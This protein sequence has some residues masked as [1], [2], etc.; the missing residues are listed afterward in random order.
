[1][2]ADKTHDQAKAKGLLTKLT[3]YKFVIHLMYMRELLAPLSR[4]SLN[5]QKDNVGIQDVLSSLDYL[6]EKLQSLETGEL[7]GDCNDD[8]KQLLQQGRD[9]RDAPDRDDDS[10]VKFQNIKLTYVSPSVS[11]FDNNRHRYASKII[12]SCGHRF[13][14]DDIFSC[15]KILD[16]RLWPTSSD[17]DS[18]SLKDFGVE[19][20]RQVTSHFATLLSDSASEVLPEWQEFKGM[21]VKNMSHLTTDTVWARLCSYYNDQYPSLCKAIK[22]LRAF[23]VSN[24][25]VERCFSAMNKES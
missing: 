24:A 11:H 9:F 4:V 8:L 10:C 7:P 20:I 17:T 2:A 22:I 23:P 14:L 19:E 21:V 15:A 5:W 16:T 25:I 12:E 1:M 18:Q 6:N 13:A 3:N